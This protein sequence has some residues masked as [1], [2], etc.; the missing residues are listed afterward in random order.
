MKKGKLI[1]SAIHVVALFLCLI[2]ATFA[3]FSNNK[4]IKSSNIGM[5]IQSVSDVTTLSAYALRYDGTIGAA[6]YKIG[7]GEGEVTD[8][9]MTEFD[10]IFRDRSVN[11]P[12][13]YVVELGNVP[14]SA[15]YNIIVKVPCSEKFI[16]VN[17]TSSNEYTDDGETP[18]VIQRYIS[19]VVSVKVNCGGAL[20]TGGLTQ[21]TTQR[22]DNNVTVFQTQ[23]TAFQSLTS[24]D[25]VGQYATVTTNGTVFSKASYVEVR[26]SQA[27]YHEYIYAGENDQGETENRLMLYI[28]FDYDQNLMDAF[29]SH[30]MDD[31]EGDVSFVDDFGVIQIL[32]RTGEN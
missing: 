31:S 26:L 14:D 19:N 27:Q 8:V 17:D 15:G 4:Q 18:F 2:L 7:D 24:G 13:I 23:K 11:T 32:V 25:A 28:Q 21:T 1:L 20:P 29:I 10:R 22:I 16:R 5:T 30:M 3:W 9:E 12:L 6:C